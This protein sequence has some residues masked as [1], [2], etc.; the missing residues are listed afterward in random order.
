[1][2]VALRRSMTADE[3]LAWE[4]GQEVKHEFDGFGPVA[5][6]GV[7]FNHAVIQGNL[8]AS[9]AARLRGT[10]CRAFGSDLKIEAAGSIRYP[11]VFVTCT[12]GPGNSTVVRDPIVVFEILSPGTAKTDRITK[13]R[14]YRATPSIRRYVMLEQDEIAA[15]VF[16]RAGQADEDWIGHILAADAVLRM[17]EIGAEVPLAEL[18]DGFDPAAG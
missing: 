12:P 6:V 13:N 5:M 3:F 14:E 8:I 10:R 11:D 16:E 18:Y 7:T 9:L 4:E 17:P 1:M 2:N 15:T